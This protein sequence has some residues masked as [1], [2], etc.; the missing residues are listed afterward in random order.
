MLKKALVFF[1]LFVNTFLFCQT[2]E[3][4]NILGYQHKYYDIDLYNTSRPSNLYYEPS[5]FF[6]YNL[7]NYMDLLFEGYFIESQKP[8]NFKNRVYICYNLGFGLDINFFSWKNLTIHSSPCYN[9]IIFHDKSETMAHKFV[10]TLYL[11][12]FAVYHHN[13]LKQDIYIGL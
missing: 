4:V 11:N 5:L 10:K 6:S 1:I 12:L 13:L 9:F 2:N 3:N 7:T 8:S